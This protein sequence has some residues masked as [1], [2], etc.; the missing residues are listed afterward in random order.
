MRFEKSIQAPGQIWSGAGRSNPWSKYWFWSLN[1]LLFLTTCRKLPE[2]RFKFKSGNFWDINLGDVTRY[3]PAWHLTWQL[4]CVIF[5]HFLAFWL[6]FVPKSYLIVLFCTFLVPFLG[7]FGEW[8][9]TE[10]VKW[11]IEPSWGMIGG[12][13]LLQVRIGTD[14]VVPWALIYQQLVTVLNIWISSTPSK[15]IYI[16]Q[17]LTNKFTNISKQHFINHRWLNHPPSGSQERRKIC[18]HFSWNL[19]KSWKI[20]IFSTCINNVVGSMNIVRRCVECANF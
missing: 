10:V 19:R 18:V 5:V 13:K 16:H 17:F 8:L 2:F 6:V 7:L 4:F 1:P 15:S 9:Y 12:S 14:F 20:C 3:G 11:L